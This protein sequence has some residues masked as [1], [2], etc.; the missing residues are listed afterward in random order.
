ML[1]GICT[2]DFIA[3]GNADDSIEMRISRVPEQEQE[4]KLL[5][6]K[7][8]LQEREHDQWSV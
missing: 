6:P 8:K 1:F 2:R 4:Y 5:Y 3:N 7:G